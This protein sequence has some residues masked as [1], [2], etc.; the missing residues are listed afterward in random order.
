[1]PFENL[2]ASLVLMDP[3]EMH[4]LRQSRPREMSR[5]VCMPI[6]LSDCTAFGQLAV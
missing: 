6:C 1:M 5:Q 4:Q 3:L 2:A